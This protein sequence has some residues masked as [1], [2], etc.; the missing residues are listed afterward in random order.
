MLCAHTRISGLDGKGVGE[1]A[2]V[3]A[4]WQAAPR[5]LGKRSGVRADEIV[6]GVEVVEIKGS[7]ESQ[8]HVAHHIRFIQS[9][10]PL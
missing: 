1:A 6:P 9:R 10:W 3:Y 4:W 7:L 8:S 5:S 2:R